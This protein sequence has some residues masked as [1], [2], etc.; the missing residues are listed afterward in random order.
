MNDVPFT[1][2]YSSDH[3]ADNLFSIQ[4]QDRC[5]HDGGTRQDDTLQRRNSFSTAVAETS[6][7]ATAA[8]QL[9]VRPSKVLRPILHV[10]VFVNVDPARVLRTGRGF[11]VAHRHIF[12]L[13]GLRPIATFV[14]T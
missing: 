6:T 4:Y 8:F 5:A 1:L 2:E 14:L 12:T 3:R 13:I 7:F 10:M 9:I 11:I